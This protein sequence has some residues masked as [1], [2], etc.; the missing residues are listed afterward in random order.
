MLAMHKDIQEKVFEEIQSEVGLIDDVKDS[1]LPR[2]PFVEMVVKETMRLFPV[3]PI[4]ARVATEDVELEKFTI[5]AGANIVISVYNAHR[6]TNTWGDD[7]HLFRPDRFSPENFEKLHPYAFLPFS[8]GLQNDVCGNCFVENVF[9]GPRMC[10]GWRYS[11]MFMKTMM[12]H[13]V[14]NFEFSTSLK[15]ENLE[16]EI[17]LTMKIAQKYKVV[18]RQRDHM[19]PSMLPAQRERNFL[20]K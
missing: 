5:P 11:M 17:S 6:N 12:V 2:L 19:T 10:I 8:R 13:L 18:V 1:D 4:H 20:R 3:L 15:Y 9:S 7:A 14:R 16:Y